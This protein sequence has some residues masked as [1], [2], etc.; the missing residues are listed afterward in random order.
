MKSVQAWRNRRKETDPILTKLVD[1]IKRKATGYGCTDQ[2]QAS[3]FT[4]GVLR[5]V[6]CYVAAESPDAFKELQR[7]LERWERQ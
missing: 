3:H 1:T 2:D 4:V 6:L 7:T 5:R